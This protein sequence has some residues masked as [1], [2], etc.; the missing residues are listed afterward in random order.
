MRDR[1]RNFLISYFHHNFSIEILIM[2]TIILLISIFISS[3][4]FGQANVSLEKLKNYNDTLTIRVS[5]H[6]KFINPEDS[7]RLKR[8]I[9]KAK[10]DS[11]STIDKMAIALP[12]RSYDYKLQ[13]YKPDFTQDSVMVK[14]IP[15]SKG[16]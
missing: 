10:S 6:G 16:Y 3:H 7:L 13:I 9:S 8:L 15:H 11:I 12:N 1:Y 14:K 2:K 5:G 4:L